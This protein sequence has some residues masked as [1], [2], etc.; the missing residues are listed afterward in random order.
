VAVWA[1]STLVTA[2][3][4]LQ[5][6]ADQ[7]KL[8]EARTEA[9]TQEATH[10]I[11][12]R[13]LAYEQVLRGGVSLFATLG[14]VSRQQWH[15]YVANLDLQDNYPG[16][17]GIGFAAHVP[18]DQ[19]K[20]F[21]SHQQAQ[22]LPQY[23]IRPP[24]ERAAYSPV[25]YLE[26]RNE[27]NLRAHGFDMFTEPNRR[28]AMEQARD[29]GE[30]AITAKLKLVSEAAQSQ[31]NG[32]LVYIPVYAS[33]LP[34]QTVE[35]RRAALRGYVNSPFRID[36][37]LKGVLGPNVGQLALTIHDG[38]SP[39][40]ENLMFSSS[41]QLP[42]SVDPASAPPGVHIKSIAIQ[43]H[44]RPWLLTF[45]S[46][47]PAHQLGL[48]QPQLLGIALG[49][50]TISLLLGGLTLALLARVRLV[51]QS[52]QHYHHLANYDALTTLSNR[53]MFQEHVQQLLSTGRTPPPFALLFIDLDNFKDVND[54]LGHHV[55]DQ[56]LREV[57]LRLRNAMRRDD[58]VARLGGDEFTVV[59]HDIRGADDVARV[60]QTLLKSISEPY[61]LGE[62]WFFVSASIGITLYPGDGKTPAD[63]LRHADQAMYAA[64]RQGK[65]HVQFFSPN[66]E[67]GL[68]DRLRLISDLRS[69]LSQNELLVVY[70]PI[71]QFSTGRIVRAEALLRWHHPRRGSVPP[72]EFIPLAEEAGLIGELG[73]WVYGQ[74]IEQVT[75]W[76][77]Q[78][79][80]NFQ[81]TVNVSPAQLRVSHSNVD[82][83]LAALE[84]AHLPGNAIGL[85][86]TEGLLLDNSLHVTQQLLKLRDAGVPVALDDF[87]TGYSSLSYL[88]R[89]DIDVLK[90]D[91]SFVASL[92]PASDALALCGAIIVMAHKLGLHVVAEGVETDEQRSLLA[93]A[94]CDFGQGYL[95]ARPMPA[96]AFG[97]F[98]ADQAD[99]STPSVAPA[100]PSSN[101]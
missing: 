90:I 36:D 23:T 56:L 98:L 83:W 15:D 87:G 92:S 46:P 24:G 12:N 59:L 72:D 6:Q 41:S 49:G 60:A 97:Q 85:E 55:G 94:G 18:A 79:D 58:T 96:A 25:T 40:E 29:T 1:L 52:A 65:G 2:G 89:L 100:T 78:W 21:V 38:T 34:T 32:F 11:H 26:P 74:A 4:W 14:D 67:D 54:T 20:A 81:I 22:G 93:E 47:D 101:T 53:A 37:L 64:K 63:L 27:R 61:Q 57:A 30:P 71:V 8:A 48:N 82:A 17:Q 19:A 43:V 10:A 13:M 9:R 95:F 62:D 50:G 39:T 45:H 73:N 66:L 16:F 76:R 3:F 75:Q 42:V 31:V 80:P 69:A 68:Q 99:P 7:L 70:Q 88:Q 44:S 5:S 33:H 77:Q 86:I 91:R 51:R 84:R 28:T 35:Q